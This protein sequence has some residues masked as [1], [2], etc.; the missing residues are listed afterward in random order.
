MYLLKIIEKKL[1]IFLYEK[2]RILYTRPQLIRVIEINMIYRVELWYFN[3]FLVNYA[4]YLFN[5]KGNA[6]CYFDIICETI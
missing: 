2:Y 3:I 5:A 4:I 6:T 1:F